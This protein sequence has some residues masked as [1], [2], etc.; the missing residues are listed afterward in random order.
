MILPKIVWQFLLHERKSEPGASAA[1]VGAH[2]GKVPHA[3]RDVT[4]VAVKL[5]HLLQQV[6]Q[7]LLGTQQ[8]L[9][10]ANDVSTMKLMNK[11]V[12]LLFYILEPTHLHHDFLWS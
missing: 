8:T 7:L 3:R 6:P 9:R 1:D 12:V 11:K 10:N 5:L 2:G 4:R